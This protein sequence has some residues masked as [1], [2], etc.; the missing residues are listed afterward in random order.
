MRRYDDPVEVRLGLVDGQ[1]APAQFCWRD[2]IWRV[3]AVAGRWVETPPWWQRPAVQGLL[4]VGEEADPPGASTA[5]AGDPSGDG[6]ADERLGV[7][8][9]AALVAER[10]HWRVEAARG[11]LGPHGTFELVRDGETGR[12]RLTGCED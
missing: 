10:E 9:V 11:R 3:R 12:W 6:T 1:E 5:R 7:V 8:S 4:G 2:R